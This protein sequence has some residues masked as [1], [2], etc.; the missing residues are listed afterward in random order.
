MAGLEV[1]FH[2]TKSSINTPSDALVCCLHWKI[3]SNGFKCI[4]LGEDPPE[5]ASKSEMLPE[6]WSG[7]STLYTL[8]YMPNDAE[9]AHLLKIIAIDGTLLVHFMRLS[10]EKTGTTNLRVADF[11]NEDLT[12]F[13]SALKNTENLQEKFQKE[14]IDELNLKPKTSSSSQNQRSDDSLRAGPSRQGRVPQY[15]PDD[16]DPLRVG[17]P[18]RGGNP[19][20][21]PSRDPFAVGRGD[22]DPLA[23]GFGGGMIMDPF[24]SGGFR[25]GP[26]PSA[27]L[28]GRL[29]PGAVPPGA[30]F[31]PFG[32]DVGPDG[33]PR[34]GGRAGPNPDHLPPPGFDDMF[35]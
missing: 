16:D 17:P 8:L 9:K 5:N 12:S 27:G 18:R 10:D 22:L 2:A 6:G 20:G 26:D 25:G 15:R 3:I 19:Y 31:D 11:A 28:P 1:L 35:M 23:G 29:P 14:V 32:P 30:R 21:M 7:D 4:G 13:N 33:Q 34:R 24:H